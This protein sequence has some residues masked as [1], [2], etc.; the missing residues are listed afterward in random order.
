M[1][2]SNAN[3]IYFLIRQWFCNFQNLL[4]FNQLDL[5]NINNHY[6]NLY[7]QRLIRW[8]KAK[9]VKEV[10]KAIDLKKMI[11]IWKIPQELKHLHRTPQI[12]NKIKFNKWISIKINLIFI[13]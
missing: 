3:N 8:E 6:I 9:K 12:N 1:I 7:N 11:K 4:N 10:I 2:K 5:K 13:K